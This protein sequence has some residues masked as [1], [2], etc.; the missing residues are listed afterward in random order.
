[1]GHA[2]IG[3]G[4]PY[5]PP[6]H[7]E[8]RGFT[9]ERGRVLSALQLV[10]VSKGQ[11]KI[12]WRTGNK[13]VA[14]GDVLVLHPG[15][16][17][18]YRPDPATGWTEDWVEFRGPTVDAWIQGGVLE[19]SSI[20]LR[21]NRRFWQRFADLHR[22][23][24]ERPLGY[25]AIAAGVAITLLAEVAS[26]AEL[27]SGPKKAALPD[28]VRGARGYLLD[29]IEVREVAHR[30][31]VSYPTLYRQFKQTTGLAPKDYAKQVRRARAEDLLAGTDLSVKEIAARLG[32]HSASHFSLEFKSAHGK[33]P[34]HFRDTGR[35]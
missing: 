34:S 8:D 22:I 23:C 1:M 15:V 24:S 19:I 27:A 10:A 21:S 7:P 17:H 9:W 4:D 35:E 3:Q 13:A 28:L 5:P 6:K 11:G 16:W 12:E 32:Y 26:S 33:A 31:G 25:R 14:T 30:L 2:R 18:R 29:G 20:S